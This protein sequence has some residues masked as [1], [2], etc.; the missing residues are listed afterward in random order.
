[1]NIAEETVQD[2]KDKSQEF[3]K[4]GPHGADAPS[5]AGEAYQHDQEYAQSL[6]LVDHS[7]KEENQ[8]PSNVKTLS[9]EL[10]FLKQTKVV[11]GQI[12]VN[13][14]RPVHLS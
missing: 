13:P 11:L 2:L 5:P 10:K 12:L 14:K 6:N 8:K 9:V 4:T 3:G 1:M 7:V